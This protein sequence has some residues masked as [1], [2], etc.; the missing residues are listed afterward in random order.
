[1]DT[2]TAVEAA[3]R[4]TDPENFRIEDVFHIVNTL[5]GNQ[6]LEKTGKALRLQSCLLLIDQ[7]LPL[8]PMKV[9]ELADM[10]PKK[11]VFKG[12]DQG[13][14]QKFFEALKKLLGMQ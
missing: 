6:Y 12:S 5:P 3:Y 11:G 4:F 8:P 13:N 7:D 9:M 10:A 14:W 1:M 2:F